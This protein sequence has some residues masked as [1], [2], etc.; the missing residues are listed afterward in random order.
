LTK[1]VEKDDLNEKFR[2][3]EEQQLI[4]IYKTTNRRRQSLKTFKVQP[5]MASYLNEFRKRRHLASL[6]P[7]ESIESR[8]RLF[9]VNDT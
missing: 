4:S 9:R 8:E 7:T 3:F 2:Q 1:E 5:L 6:P